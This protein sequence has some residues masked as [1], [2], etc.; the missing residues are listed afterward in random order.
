MIKWIVI[1]VVS[2]SLAVIAGALLFP[3]KTVVTN[4]V[5]TEHIVTTS[6]NT[7]LAIV[8]DSLKDALIHAHIPLPPIPTIN[9]I[10]ETAFYVPQKLTILGLSLVEHELT[11]S[12][13]DSAAPHSRRE[14][15]TN[16][17]E[18]VTV[19]LD[20]ISKE[21]NYKSWTVTKPAPIIKKWWRPTIEGGAVWYT[22]NNIE[23]FVSPS[24]VLIDHLKL[25]VIGRADM[26]NIK[27][28]KIGASASIEW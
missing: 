17:Q 6:D 11:I 2:L 14:T 8:R 4:N 20:T 13:F 7:A 18:N 1:G 23:F 27:E 21:W 16:V 26:G 15:W 3:R 22:G 10:P 9:P 28:T 24:I 25:G 12:C 19:F 5:V